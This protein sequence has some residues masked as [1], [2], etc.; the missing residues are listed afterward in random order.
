MSESLKSQLKH[1]YS[2]IFILTRQDLAYI[3]ELVRL[4]SASRSL[5]S[6]DDAVS[7]VRPKE[8]GPV[9]NQLPLSIKMAAPICAFKSHLKAPSNTLISQFH[10]AHAGWSV[11]LDAS[12]SPLLCQDCCCC[13]WLFCFFLTDCFLHL[14]CGW[15]VSIT[16]V[17]C[18]QISISQTC[19]FLSCGA[20]KL[21][22]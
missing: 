19:P 6:A 13:T 11:H 1:L 4:Y 3:I 18:N 9:W 8:M 2:N 22:C 16:S 17:M 20:G 7:H 10:W 5:T 12:V 21:C 15:Y 14:H